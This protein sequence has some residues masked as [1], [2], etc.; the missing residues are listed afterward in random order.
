MLGEP[1]SVTRLGN[2]WLELV[3][4]GIVA[5]LAAAAAALVRLC[6]SPATIV[7]AACLVCALRNVVFAWAGESPILGATSARNRELPVATISE[8]LWMF[9]AISL[10]AD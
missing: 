6:S 5:E 2:D 7:A 9:C 1:N 3:S 10:P 4:G 8:E